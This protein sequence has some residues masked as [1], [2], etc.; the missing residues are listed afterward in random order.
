M[1]QGDMDE[2]AGSRSPKTL[3]DVSHL[4]FSRVEEG[5]NE[6]PEDAPT[7]FDDEPRAEDDSRVHDD[8]A[9]E[10][11]AEPS[12]EIES[13]ARTRVFVVTGGD[14]APGKSTVAVNLAHAL[15]P[16]G[17]VALF[18]ADSSVPNARFYI[19]L[20]SW[21]Y[22]SPLT[23]SGESAPDVVTDA[24]VLVGD[25]SNDGSGPADSMGN[26]PVIFADVP[27]VGR[28]AMD[29]VV[30]DVPAS[31]N[32]LISWLATRGPEY[33]IAARGG[34]R[35][36][37]SA[38]V[39]LRSLRAW[40]G[41]GSAGLVVNRVPDGEASEFH[42]KIAAAARRLLSVEVRLLGSVP[43]EPGIG[44]EQRERGA[45]VASRP[46]ASAALAMRAIATGLLDAE[47]QSGRTRG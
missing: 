3:A 25:W 20:P 41:A 9:E 17:R 30:V 10:V 7:G 40:A 27:D 38:F 26:G 28:A 2:D 43:T 4:F 23:G 46:D 29:F 47:E 34:R 11:L 12:A 6:P 35:G 31:N 24:G 44:A 37:E 5:S 15:V 21:H 22:L 36:F 45:L 18:D 19:G 1:G 42:A 8:S 32:E 39:A 13:H 14:D 33:V 16:H